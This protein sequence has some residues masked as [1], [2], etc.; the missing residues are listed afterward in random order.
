MQNY[1]QFIIPRLNGESIKKDLGKYLT[2]V[3]KGIAGFIIFGG[4]LEE[5]RRH[6][7][8]LQEES[9]LPLI[10]ASDLERGVGQQLKGG[11]LF[12][13][14]M[15]LAKASLKRGSGTTDGQVVISRDRR[16]LLRDSFT[17]VAEEARYA[18]INTI[19]A[20]V[21]DINTN[22][23][24]PIISV[25]S[26]GED[27]ETVSFF[28]VEMIKALQDAGVAACG[29]HFP[30]H[31]DTET[32]SHISLPTVNKPLSALARNELRP[33]RAAVGAGV[34]MLMLGHLSVPAIDAS[35]L[36]VSVS[37]KAVNYL[38]K[39]M[40]YE[41]I[42]ITDAM[43]MG[44]LSRYS[45][46]EASLM[47]LK[48]GVDIVLHP[49]N[50]EKV[51]SFLKDRAIQFN[52]GRL[53][54]FRQGLLIKSDDSKP[55]FNF[56][57]VLSERLT[58]A[59]ITLTGRFKTERDITLIVINDGGRPAGRTFIRAL[60][61]RVPGIKTISLSP[62]KETA[63]TALNK[64]DKTGSVITAI[65][66]ETR[67]WKGNTGSRLSEAISD[68]EKISDLFISFGNPYL[69][70]KVS[71]TPRMPVYWDSE[72][73]QKTAAEELLKHIRQK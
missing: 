6:L 9:R 39:T 11:T 26:F 58:R 72:S 49:I 37:P 71:E 62:E 8:I 73:A 35:G 68:C 60:K 20:P 57:A 13:P 41:G 23:D 40:G 44:G 15:A 25:R 64:I 63:R 22:P 65:F 29:K 3:R 33:F 46:E 42:L 61:T 10:I 36:P 7:K 52:A 70:N 59:S 30:G 24:N 12:P 67:A 17:A 55:L 51:V 34:R 38:R 48:A 32:D 18:G 27:R 5:V 56:N 28:G 19:L 50:P 54:L 66:S 2:L 14:A 45:E 31:G 4:R 69:L 43:N 16:K 1:Y 53:D 47:A 21:L